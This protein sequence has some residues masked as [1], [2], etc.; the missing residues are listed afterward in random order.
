M[1]LIVWVLV[2]VVVVVVV[3]VVFVFVVGDVA[4]GGGQPL[5]LV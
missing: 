5:V 2:A 3:V 4:V 1:G